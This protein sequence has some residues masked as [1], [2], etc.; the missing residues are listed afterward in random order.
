M[1][2]RISAAMMVSGTILLLI[3]VVFSTVSFAAP[4]A[5]V[6]SD[7]PPQG[8]PD[9][10]QQMEVLQAATCTRDK[11]CNDGDKCTTDHCID[12]VCS[13]PPVVCDDGD[14]CTDDSC[15]PNNGKCVTSNNTAPCND[16]DDCTEGDTCA[17]G[18]CQPG[19]WICAAECEDDSDCDDT[20]SCTED[21]C[22][23][24]KCKYVNYCCQT[25][26]TP[27]CVGQPIGYQFETPGGQ[28]KECEGDPGTGGSPTHCHVQPCGGGCGSDV[29][30][31]DGA[32]CNG[33]ETCD[34]ATGEC[35]AGTPVDCNDGDV[36][37]D[38]SCD[39]QNDECLYVFNPS[40]DPSCQIECNS[41]PECDDGAFCNGSEACV[42]G[43]CVPGTPVDCDDG[44]ECTVDSCN[45]ASDA[46]ANMPNHSLC[47]DGAFCN[48]EETCDATLDCQPG[49]APDC[50]DLDG[51]TE[52]YCDEANDTC[53]HRFVCP[54]EEDSECSDGI[55][56]TVDTCDDN[57]CVYT[58]DDSFCDNEVF[59][60]GEETCD[61]VLG[62]QDGTPPNCDDGDQCTIDYCD[63]T[64]DDCAGTPIDPRYC[65]TGP[66]GTINVGVC[67]EGMQECSDDEWGACVGE[68]LPS[69][70]ICDGLDNDC[71]G[72][73]DEGCDCVDGETR[74]CG[75]DVG[76]CE[77]GTQTCVDGVWGD[78]DG[79]VGPS[80]E[81]CDGKDN[82]CDGKIDEGGVC[83]APPPEGPEPEPPPTP[84]P[85]PVV[86][87][88]GV[89]AL[90]TAGIMPVG[91]AL[92]ILPMIF[93][94]LALIGGGLL[95]WGEE[96]E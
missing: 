12:G 63:T 68:V 28:C 24:G 52:D 40:N 51:C 41:D 73:V 25:S 67:K 34:T 9:E 96:D 16:G 78:C 65:Y 87:V 38:D 91:P 7:E 57:L 43:S 18:E 80:P 50:D 75:S 45:E 53:A 14:P 48:G 62:C 15:N 74:P 23:S 58:P 33:S 70:E 84:T 32:F 1:K 13:N 83:G 21:S 29:D 93:S 42:D 37:T 55:D 60:D 77:R 76:E 82:D 59:C 3:S 89:E 49:I 19:E 46:C 36:C 92:P 86:E 71:D 11:D 72:A 90:P 8:T 30:C 85:T 64:A 88:L 26:N 22:V 81:V 95:L 94:S 39:E 31:D 5:S 61:E 66:T 4:G 20:D 35:Q 10:G 56:C 69:D 54:C 44:V 2:R 6:L 47:D 17:D 27:G 79:A